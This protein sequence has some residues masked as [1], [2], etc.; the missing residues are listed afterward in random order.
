VTSF[1]VASISSGRVGI[2]QGVE[3]ERDDCFEGVG[4]GAV[5][6]VFWQCLEPCGVF[7]LERQQHGNGISPSLGTA[8]PVGA[9]AWMRGGQ[10]RWRQAGTVAGLTLGIA[11]GM[12]ALW[13]AASRHR[14]DLR[15]VTHCRWS[16]AGVAPVGHSL[17]FAVGARPPQDGVRRARRLNLSRDL[18]GIAACPGFWTLNGIA[19][20]VVPTGTTPHPPWSGGN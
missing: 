9:T 18:R 20:P 17:L 6:E 16:A 12:V 13:P 8:A 11:E 10:R 19:S 1:S 2:G 14:V 4:G 7:D 3:V 15:Y 5:M